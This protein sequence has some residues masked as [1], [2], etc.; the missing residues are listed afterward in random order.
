LEKTRRLTRA[1]VR[2][3]VN[4]AW[5]ETLTRGFGF[6]PVEARQTLRDLVAPGRAA[7]VSKDKGLAEQLAAGISVLF[8][9][10][11]RQKFEE[12]TRK[13]KTQAELERLVQEMREMSER[14]PTVTRAALQSLSKILPRRG[15]PGRRPK[16]TAKEA[17][18]ACNH[19]A[20]FIRSGLNVK[21]ALQKCADLSLQVLG[22][23]VGSRT[24]QKAW[25]NRVK[26]TNV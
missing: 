7:D 26:L 23:K 6:T 22:K 9:M 21:Q 4:E 19:I 24:L 11:G 16:L 12:R 10:S 13:V 8:G 2:K 18:E 17:N 14:L 25:N 3:Q 5:D 15:G 20:V 1:E